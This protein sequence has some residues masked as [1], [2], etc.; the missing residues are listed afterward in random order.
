MCGMRCVEGRRIIWKDDNKDYLLVLKN[1][2][3]CGFM[4][5]LYSLLVGLGISRVPLFTPLRHRHVGRAPLQ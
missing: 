3:S 4:G 2:T 5:V 1:I